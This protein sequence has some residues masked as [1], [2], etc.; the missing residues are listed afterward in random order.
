[1][2]IRPLTIQ[3]LPSVIRVFRLAN[4]EERRRGDAPPPSPE[5]ILQE[6]LVLWDQEILIGTT[7]VGV[8]EGRLVGFVHWLEQGHL[9]LLEALPGKGWEQRVRALLQFAESRLEEMGF[10]SMSAQVNHEVRALMEGQKFRMVRTEWIRINELQ[11]LRAWMVLGQAPYFE[12]VAENDR[13]SF[14][15]RHM[16]NFH[17]RGNLV[18]MVGLGVLA[19]LVLFALDPILL[20]GPEFHSPFGL[21][22][23]RAFIYVGAGFAMV[24]TLGAALA[25]DM[26]RSMRAGMFFGSGAMAALLGLVILPVS[27]LGVFFLGLGLLGLT[28]WVVSRLYFRVGEWA[29]AEE[30]VRQGGVPL[31]RVPIACG[32]LLAWLPS[33]A[34]Q[35]GCEARVDW[36]IARIEKGGEREMQA[37]VREWR[38]LYWL[39]HPG[40]ML[41]YRNESGIMP[42]DVRRRLIETYRRIAEA[43]GDEVPWLEDWMP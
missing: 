22:R 17:P 2:E 42:A 36:H 24:N 43:T 15:Q 40:E 20:H 16:A 26:V 31:S 1:M 5:V 27:F 3:D 32:V 25:P 38:Y 35:R 8:E 30:T 21:S 34:V 6:D 29:L 41:S 11:T 28:P 39:H 37:A 4:R 10:T 23:Y 9:S 19:P 14:L 7:Y 12:P 18:G 13:Q 33:F